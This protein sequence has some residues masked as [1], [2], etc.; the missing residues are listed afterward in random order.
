[1]FLNCVTLSNQISGNAPVLLR[2]DIPASIRRAREYGYDAVELHLSDPREFDTVTCLAA[3]KA[4]GIKVGGIATGSTYTVHHL[5]LTDHAKTI[6]DAAVSRVIEYVELAAALSGTLII[7]CV[8]GNIADSA[9]SSLILQRLRETIGQISAL[10]QIRQVP[11]VIEAI[12]RY[13][14][15]YLNNAY[16]TIE[17][18]K[19]CPVPNLKIL[20]DTFHMNIEEINLETSIRM[21]KEHLGY[22]HIADSNRMYPGAGHIDFKMIVNTLSDIGYQGFVSVECNALPDGETAARQSIGHIR[23][24]MPDYK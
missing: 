9:Q 23:R 3:C 21:S 15:N 16:E 19:S 1:M 10:A 7:G 11:I 13:E 5:S 24:M 6:R 12:N 2:G 4:N 20:L 18:I 14:N 22:L 17:F 8:R